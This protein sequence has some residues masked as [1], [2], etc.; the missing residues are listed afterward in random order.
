MFKN[1]IEDD[2]CHLFIYGGTDTKWIQE[3]TTAI[4]TMK[5]QVEKVL[6]MDITIES[7]QLGKEDSKV[8]PRFWIA[9]DSLL[10]RRRQN[11]KG[12]EGVQEFAISEIKRL[13]SLK[14]DPKGWVIFSKGYNVK[15]LGHGEP[16]CETVKDFA[17]KWHGKLHEHV[18]SFDAAF[19][20][21]YE[22]IKVKDCHKKCAQNVIS[23]NYPTDIVERIPCPNKDCRRAMGVTSV[24]YK[25]CHQDKES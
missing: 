15:L 3:F 24:K 21:Y 18:M 23:Y 10:T 12:G 11:M 7:Y 4:E 6:Q 22:G 1:Q 5:R 8:V 16:M 19:K 9:I 17:E 25:C 20:E 2:N 14:Q 13:L